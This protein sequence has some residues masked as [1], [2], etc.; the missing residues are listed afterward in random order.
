MLLKI[1]EQAKWCKF[2]GINKLDER[3]GASQRLGTLTTPDLWVDHTEVKNTDMGIFNFFLCSAHF[4]VPLDYEDHRY[5]HLQ[6]FFLCSTHFKV[7][8]D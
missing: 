3:L 2:F 4:K 6:F 8:L 1:A 7:P 5:G